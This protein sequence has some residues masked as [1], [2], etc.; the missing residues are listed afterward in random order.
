M[1]IQSAMNQV[2]KETGKMVDER[3]NRI[4]LEQNKL[5]L[6]QELT[7]QEKINELRRE[8]MQMSV[9]NNYFKKQ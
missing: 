8:I 4:M 6:D 7:F 9:S 5:R 2:M 1:E 3:I